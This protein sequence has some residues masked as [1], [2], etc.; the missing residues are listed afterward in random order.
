MSLVGSD[1]APIFNQIRCWRGVKII[2]N[3]HNFID[4]LPEAIRLELEGVCIVRHV[5]KDESIYSSG[6]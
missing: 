3:F 6:G 5:G 1:F 2:P 4:V